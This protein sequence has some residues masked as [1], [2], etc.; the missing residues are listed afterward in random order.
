P[1]SVV[2][3][4]AKYWMSDDMIK[5]WSA[6]NRTTRDVFQD[7]DTNMLL[8]AWH[9][10]LKGTL[11]QGKRNRRLDHL[12]FILTELAEQHFIARHQRQEFGFEGPDLEVQK[13][14]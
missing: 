11:M 9:H 2:E 3:Y 12:I 14:I 10:V 7:C 6:T 13:T 1:P 4:L 8:E 5:M